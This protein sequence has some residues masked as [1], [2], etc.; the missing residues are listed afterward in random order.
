M[1]DKRTRK[2]LEQ[3]DEF[4]AIGWQVLRYLSENREKFYL[5]GAAVLLVVILA[6]A[7]YLYRLNYENKAQGLYSSAHN[8]SAVPVK[9]QEEKNGAYLKAL[10]IYEELVK[11]YPSSHAATLSYYH[12]GNLYFDVGEMEKAITSYKAFLKRSSDDILTALTYHGLGYCYEGVEDYDNA[13]KSFENSN[14]RLRGIRFEY[15]NY[16]NIARIYEAMGRKKEA[17][18]FYGKAAGKV[19]DPILEMLVKRKMAALAPVK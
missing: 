3:P 19:Q 5:A 16:A 14:K 4:H 17:L 18:E 2:E 6:G 15:I 9:S 11:E 1:V 13:L 10:G 7:W 8:T 12:M